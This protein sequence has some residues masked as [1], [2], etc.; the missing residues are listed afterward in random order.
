VDLTFVAYEFTIFFLQSI[1][2][3]PD[4]GNFSVAGFATKRSALKLAM[5]ER[6]VSEAK[7]KAPNLNLLHYWKFI[8]NL[9]M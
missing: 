3:K 1:M 4:A 5:A 9:Q 7:H 8:G 2:P 6:S